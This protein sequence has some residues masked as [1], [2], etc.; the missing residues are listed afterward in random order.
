MITL[1]KGTRKK[2]RMENGLKHWRYKRRWK[3]KR[4]LPGYKI[5][6]DRDS[7]RISG[8]E[9]SQHGPTRM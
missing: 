8:R 7:I 5:S 1:H 9:L 3:L 2:P 6:G 4:P